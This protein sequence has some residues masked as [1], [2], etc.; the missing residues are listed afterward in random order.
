MALAAP[1]LVEL[2]FP[3]FLQDVTDLGYFLN[4]LQ[5]RNTQSQSQGQGETRGPCL[6]ITYKG[7]QKKKPFLK[8]TSSIPKNYHSHLKIWKDSLSKTNKQKQG[9]TAL[10]PGAD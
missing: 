10:I 6:G 7:K 5:L 3:F 1:Q 2:S 4:L 9:L 8:R